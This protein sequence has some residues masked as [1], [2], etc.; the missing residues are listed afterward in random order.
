MLDVSTAAII[1]EFISCSLNNL[2]INNVGRC[3]LKI[4][5][6]NIIIVI[7]I[8]GSF[9]G[10]YCH[11]SCLPVDMLPRL[12]LAHGFLWF[13]MQVPNGAAGHYLLGLI[14]RFFAIPTPNLVTLIHHIETILF[15]GCVTLHL[16]FLIT[17]VLVLIRKL[18]WNY[19]W[20]IS[21][22]NISISW[23]GVIFLIT[24]FFFQ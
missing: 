3:G 8:F 16:V 6:L 5:L 4:T 9:C 22:S 10:N 12:G 14:Y 24:I 15:W 18:V 11:C 23:F 13:A 2:I 19:L 17:L 1:N 20:R 7:I 21:C